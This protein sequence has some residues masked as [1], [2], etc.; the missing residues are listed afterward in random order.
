MQIK[1]FGGIRVSLNYLAEERSV[2][3]FEETEA[4]ERT[5]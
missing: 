4:R 2:H 5:T 1:I 3:A